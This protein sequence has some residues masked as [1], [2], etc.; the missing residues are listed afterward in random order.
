MKTTPIAIPAALC[1]LAAA[2]AAPL[3]A[4]AEPRLDA[5]GKTLVVPDGLAA[6]GVVY[7]VVP[8]KP[9]AD[10]DQ[11]RFTNNP[12]SK[13]APRM[14]T[15]TG[16][17]NAAVGYVVASTGDP[18][19]LLSGEFLLP[20]SSLDTGIKRRNKHLSQ[21]QWLSIERHPN[22]VFSLQG[23]RSLTADKSQSSFTTY[24][25]EIFGDMT[26]KGVTRSF[27]FPA[28]ITV[29]PQSD[30]TRAVAP[31]DLLAIRAAY[32]IKLSDFGVDNGI[33]GKQVADN[34]A[35]EQFLVLSTHKPAP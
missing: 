33:I 14:A 27:A 25:G 9:G 6:K 32:T 16:Q 13:K 7:Y 5:G 28:S 18:A 2:S 26:V 29:M 1:L 22:I 34:I 8:G 19:T 31:G 3:G 35:I 17:S 12:P 4:G 11:T 21:E 30:R 20:A 23:V 10:A 15:F 24:K